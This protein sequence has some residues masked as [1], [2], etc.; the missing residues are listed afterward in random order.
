[1]PGLDSLSA[2]HVPLKKRGP[3]YIEL[4]EQ[5]PSTSYQFLDIISLVGR[6]ELASNVRI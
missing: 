4:P 1:V 2:D 5:P 6:L 3:G